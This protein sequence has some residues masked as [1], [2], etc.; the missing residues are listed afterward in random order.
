[1]EGGCIEVAR[2]NPGCI[3]HYDFEHIVYFAKL[4]FIDGY[5]T[6]SLMQR[7]RSEIEREEVAMVCMLDIEDELVLNIKLNCRY[8]NDCKITDCRDRLR[9]LIEAELKSRKIS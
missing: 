5:S 6:I 4:R 2:F 8:A 7:A 9:S 1:M 3:G